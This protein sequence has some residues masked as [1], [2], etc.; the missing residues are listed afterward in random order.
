M[1]IVAAPCGYFVQRKKQAI[2]VSPDPPRRRCAAM[3][4]GSNAGPA[5]APMPS[6]GSPA[7]SASLARQRRVVE[8]GAE[9]RLRGGQHL[10]R[11]RRLTPAHHLRIEPGRLDRIGPRCAV[12]ADQQIAVA[13]AHGAVGRHLHAAVERA[14]DHFGGDADAVRRREDRRDL[15][16]VGRVLDEGGGAADA[17]APAAAARPDSRPPS[18][19]A[20]PAPSRR[21]ARGSPTRNAG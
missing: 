10:A 20:P 6:A 12:A 19:R 2:Y 11:Q 7:R 3:S 15:V 5:K 4:S 1:P 18:A 17:R 13:G 9:H 8:I 14:A 21:R 16:A